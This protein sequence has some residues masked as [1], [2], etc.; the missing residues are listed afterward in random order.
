MSKTWEELEATTP[1]RDPAQDE[2]AGRQ[3]GASLL[4]HMIMGAVEA[5]SLMAE[6]RDP[7]VAGHLKHVGELAEAIAVEMGLGPFETEGIRISGH[8]HDI[9]KV[10]VPSEILCKPALL[11]R[12]EMRIVR[13]HP[14]VAR[15]ILKRIPFPWPVA[16]TVYQ[17]AERLDGSGYPQGLAGDEILLSARIVGVAD[18][19]QAML[20]FRPYRPAHPLD[21]VMAQLQVNRG[22]LYDPQV[23]DAC[24]HLFRAGGFRFSE[25]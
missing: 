3:P 23:V 1:R 20:S 22:R 17:H 14:K 18:T 4:R 25:D 24:T 2:T 16:E 13:T 6:Q 9:G 10:A 5:M 11:S 8:L 21:D 12:A 15:R 19:V 7:F